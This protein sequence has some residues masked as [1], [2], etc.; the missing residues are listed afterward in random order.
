MR[1]DQLRVAHLGAVAQMHAVRRLAHA[2]LAAG[3]D[4]LAVAGADRLGA[5]RD[6]AQAR[7]AQLVDADRRSSRPGCRPPMAAWRAGFWPVA[8]GQDLAQDDLR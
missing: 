5:E 1:V 8:G 7:A 6:G 3:D 2:L 4:D